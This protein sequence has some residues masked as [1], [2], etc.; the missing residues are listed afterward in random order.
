M[1]GI[2]ETRGRIGTLL[3]RAN[4]RQFAHI[5]CVRRSLHTVVPGS[6]LPD[7]VAIDPFREMN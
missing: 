7:Q 5:Q 4:V 3:Y 2:S 1:R 6:F